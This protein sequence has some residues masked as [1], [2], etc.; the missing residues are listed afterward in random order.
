LAQFKWLITAVRN[1][2]CI[3]ADSFTGLFAPVH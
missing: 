3:H 1:E 2:N